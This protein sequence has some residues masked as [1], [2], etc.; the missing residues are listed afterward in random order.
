MFIVFPRHKQ[1]SRHKAG[2]T[3]VE[4]LV[5][6]AII[7]VLVALLLP[8]VQ[9][10]REASQRMA[11]TNN[12]KQL[13]LGVHNFA[14]AKSAIPPICVF[15]NHMTLFPILFPYLEQDAAYD[16]INT[17]NPPPST[18]PPADWYPAGQSHG[19][20]FR[21]PYVTDEQRRA[22]SSIPFMKCPSRRDG[23]QMLPVGAYAGPKGDYA[24]ITTKTAVGGGNNPFDWWHVFC[25]RSTESCATPEM[26]KGPFRLP[27]LVFSGGVDGSNQS[28]HYSSLVSWT[29][30]FDFSLWQDG[31]SNQLIFGEKFVPIFA[32]DS[33]DGT[34][35]EWD[36]SYITVWSEDGVFGSTRFV[37]DAPTTPPI[38]RS[39]K[40]PG[41]AYLTGPRSYWGAY[42]F[43]SHHP[44][45][46]NFALGDGSVRPFVVSTLP[47]VIVSMTDVADG[48]MNGTP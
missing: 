26:F 6:I 1:G 14:S 8:A 45:V 7:G 31:T 2:F 44:T 28:S 3:L 38:A 33:L 9:A 18:P 17:R 30:Q 5:V 32:L 12:L 46:C 20:W 41:V 11:C 48:G 29:P 22:L 34:V 25:F 19:T 15:S 13:A 39:P 24:V 42:G 21:G 37:Q 36:Q 10:A 47:A 23:V 40:D 35:S 27:T 4:L 16:L 43:G